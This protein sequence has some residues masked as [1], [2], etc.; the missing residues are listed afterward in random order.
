MSSFKNFAPTLRSLQAQADGTGTIAGSPLEDFLSI[1]G[2]ETPGG[3]GGGSSDFSTAQVTII[4]DEGV[5]GFYTPFMPMLTPDGLNCVGVYQE[6]SEAT[7]SVLLYKGSVS[8]SVGYSISVVSTSGAIELDDYAIVTG[9]CSI[10]VRP[11]D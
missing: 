4:G 1:A 10:T 8:F 3:G 6:E 11:L 7:Y 5:T 9:D 2:Y